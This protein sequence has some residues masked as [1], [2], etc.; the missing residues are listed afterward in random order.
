[1]KNGFEKIYPY[2]HL[3]LCYQGWIELGQDQHS[4]SWVRVLDIGGMRLE[5]DE[6]TLDESLAKAEAWAKVWMTENY[7]KEV[8][9]MLCEK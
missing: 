7:E 4:D 3:F 5:V 9:E 1:M 6:K 2:L 8:R